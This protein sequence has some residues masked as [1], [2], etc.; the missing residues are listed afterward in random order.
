MSG[1]FRVCKTDLVTICA[2]LSHCIAHKVNLLDQVQVHQPA[3]TAPL[4][5]KQHIST[6]KRMRITATSMI[7]R[8]EADKNDFYHFLLCC[9]WCVK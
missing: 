9:V 8:E 4:A 1:Q 7:V 2:M 6:P 5:L 3:D